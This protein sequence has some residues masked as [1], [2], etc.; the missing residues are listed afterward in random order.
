MTDKRL[1]AGQIIADAL[2]ASVRRLCIITTHPGEWDTA[3]QLRQQYPDQVSYTLGIHPHNAKDACEQDF[4][5]LREQLTQPGV[6]AVGECGLDFNRNFS[7][8][9]VQI[10]V[11]KRQLAIAVESGLP[12]YLHERD[13]FETQLACRSPVIDALSGGIA[14]CFTQGMTQLHGY[15]Q[16]GLYIGITGWV[17]DPKRGADLRACLTDLPLE[18]LILETDAPY[19]FPKTLR[20][21][22][23]NNTPACLPHIGEQVARLYGVDTPRISASSYANTCQL[24]GIDD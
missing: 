2:S 9:D 13:A 14:H 12:V 20:P 7:P 6:V 17:C 23:R 15:L 1:D 19:L 3:R 5:R 18:K 21:R 11:F 10:E 4:A 22:Q 24:F 16:L 8:P